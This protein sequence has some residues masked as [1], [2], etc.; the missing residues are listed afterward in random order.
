MVHLKV[1]EGRNKG[2]EFV[3]HAT[4]ITVGRWQDCTI[5][6]RDPRVS[7]RHGEIAVT[8]R[9]LLYRDLYSANGSALDR[10]EKGRIHL[11]PLA[12]ECWISEGDDILVGDSRLRVT[13]FTEQRSMN[14]PAEDSRLA[15]QHALHVAP[16][17]TQHATR[18][19]PGADSY[20]QQDPLMSFNL[21]LEKEIDDPTDV[22][23]V[24][25]AL[26]EAL[27][28]ACPTANC[29]ALVEI[30]GILVPGR[31]LKPDLIDDETITF[32]PAE[33]TGG[34]RPGRRFSFS[35]M[36]EAAARRSPVVFEYAN[37]TPNE[38]AP[39]SIQEIGM[40]S[41]MCSPLWR[42]GDILGFVQVYANEPGAE[43]FRK[44]EFDAF[45]I[46]V[47]VA[48]LVLNQAKQ[49]DEQKTLEKWACVS[50]QVA[51]L[52]HNYSP[53][54]ACMDRNVDII[55]KTMPRVARIE[56]WG[57]LKHDVKFMRSTSKSLLAQV[58]STSEHDD[59]R[60]QLEEIPVRQWVDCSLTEAK[61]LYVSGVRPTIDLHNCCGPTHTVLAD[62]S[63]LSMILLNC[64]S[65]SVYAV[66]HRQGAH[67]PIVMGS[68][69]D[70]EMPETHLTVAVC[71]EGCGIPED[72][73]NKLGVGYYTT[74]KRGRGIGFKQVVDVARQ[75]GGRVRLA[76]YASTKPGAQPG[77]VV[78]ISLPKPSSRR[79]G[80]PEGVQPFAW[81]PNYYQFRTS[82]VDKFHQ[83]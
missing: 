48:S 37:D 62:R 33:D 77:T 41:C 35:V 24:R 82:L 51:A 30:K 58:V 29:A 64:I 28:R 68:C 54:L 70:D 21:F 23:Q 3:T 73:L 8:G 32:A 18:L 81:V 22:R 66:T 72:V 1:L 19:R 40:L 45:S 14:T 9:G 10:R 67:P 53:R 61:R 16:P 31:E 34:P 2:E 43:P 46:I 4:L 27:R 7:H 25:Q 17:P 60:S 52:H 44:R 12:S 38:R 75:L 83:I 80:L 71:D 59:R 50:Q 11:S 5:T 69:D 26:C 42:R 36:K 65:N 56:E 13:E 57:D 79:I 49:A 63:E 55:Q 39:R 47:S 6:L 20:V 78:A 74:K 15:K 76:S